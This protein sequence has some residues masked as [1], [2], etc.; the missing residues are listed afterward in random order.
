MEK[1]TQ[2]TFSHS[3]FHIDLFIIGFD[4]VLQ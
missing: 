2:P 4:L 3:L 1:P